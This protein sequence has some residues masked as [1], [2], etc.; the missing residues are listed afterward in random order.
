MRGSRADSIINKRKY[1]VNVHTK[2]GGK[3]E[4]AKGFEGVVRGGRCVSLSQVSIKR[5]RAIV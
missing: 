1:L 3:L 4:A 2:M 5:Q